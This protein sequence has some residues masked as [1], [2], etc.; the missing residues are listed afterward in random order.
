MKYNNVYAVLQA[1]AKGSLIKKL[2]YQHLFLSLSSQLTSH[3]LVFQSKKIQTTK[4]KIKLA[5]LCLKLYVNFST[6]SN[7]IS[8]T[9]HTHYCLR[10][11]QTI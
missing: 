9:L 8:Y 2:L 3:F 1:F 11:I 5:L 7:L 6:F 4:A 10:N